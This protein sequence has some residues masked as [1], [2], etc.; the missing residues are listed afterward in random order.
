[1][2]WIDTQTIQSQID[3][4]DLKS[5]IEDEIQEE[6]Y[7]KTEIEYDFLKNIEEVFQHNQFKYKIMLCISS[8]EKKIIHQK[9][10]M[11]NDRYISSE[12][13]DWTRQLQEKL[14]RYNSD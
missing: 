10:I 8:E 14:W 11:L 13:Y 2:S 4:H 3:F 12:F 9:Y 5:M 7:R 6:K 1:M